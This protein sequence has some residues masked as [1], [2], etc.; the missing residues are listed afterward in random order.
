M[1]INASRENREWCR[2]NILAY[3]AS[4]TTLGVDSTMMY[5]YCSIAEGFWYS[6]RTSQNNSLGNT[7]PSSP[8]FPSSSSSSSESSRRPSAVPYRSSR[9]PARFLVWTGV[10][11]NIQSERKL[12]PELGVWLMGITVS[13]VTAMPTS[14]FYLLG[15]Q[16]LAILFAK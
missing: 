1:N 16:G 7:H 15:I 8:S 13:G 12:P 6:R 3:L 5:S 2:R 11:H 9:W 14:G 4:A 10:G